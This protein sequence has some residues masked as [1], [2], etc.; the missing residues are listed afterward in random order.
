MSLSTEQNILGISEAKIAEVTENS[1]STYTIGARIELSELKT[2]D[3]TVKKV[4]KTAEAQNIIVDS[5]II[6]QAYDVKFESVNI[7]LSVIALINGSDLTTSEQMNKLT[8]KGSD[9]P[10]QFNLAFKTES[11]NGAVADFHMELY[12]V[13]GL[14]DIVTKADDYWTCSFT[15]LACARKKDKAFRDITANETITEISST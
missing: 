1:S 3:V 2:L 5:F 6:K 7:P 11:I 12:R 14:I 10:V 4:E 13:K 8:D 15:G 9:I